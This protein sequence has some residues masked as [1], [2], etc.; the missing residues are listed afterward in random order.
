MSLVM[1]DFS[2]RMLTSL[3]ED[4]V[5]IYIYKCMC[6]CVCVKTKQ[7]QGQNQPLKGGKFKPFIVLTMFTSDSD[8]SFIK[9]KVSSPFGL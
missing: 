5:Y 4:D 2:L 3:S 6:V 1:H 8:F 7:V 9:K